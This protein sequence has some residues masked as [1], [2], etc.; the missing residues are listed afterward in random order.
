MTLLVTFFLPHLCERWRGGNKLVK[1]GNNKSGWSE[2]WLQR[3]L[4]SREGKSLTSEDL[5]DARARTMKREEQQKQNKQKPRIEL[6]RCQN[7]LGTSKRRN[8]WIELLNN[9]SVAGKNSSQLNLEKP[10]KHGLKSLILSR[11]G[12]SD[13]SM[14]G[15][16]R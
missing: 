14:S 5:M 4:I 15:T 8:C 2:G 16:H 6:L 7:I 12:F 13:A 3:L 9:E 11:G 10:P 1:C